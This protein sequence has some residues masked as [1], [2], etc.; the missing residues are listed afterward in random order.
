MAFRHRRLDFQP[1]EGSHLPAQSTRHRLS[2]DGCQRNDD[3]V[4]GRRQVQRRLHVTRTTT[5]PSLSTLRRCRQQPRLAVARTEPFGR[6][7]SYPIVLFS[8]SLGLSRPSYTVQG[9]R[10]SFQSWNPPKTGTVTRE[11]NAEAAIDMPRRSACFWLGDPGKGP[12]PKVFAWGERRFCS[13]RKVCD[14]LRAC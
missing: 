14:P 4:A 9:T 3:G 10:C 2:S 12:R 11:C 1:L 6:F 5:S 8:S 7:P 13:L